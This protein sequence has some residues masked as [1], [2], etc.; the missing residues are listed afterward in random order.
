MDEIKAKGSLAALSDLKLSNL[1]V[2]GSYEKLEGIVIPSTTEEFIRDEVDKPIDL[3]S[4]RV[5]G[6]IRFLDMN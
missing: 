6:K 5:R 3:L 2:G 4:E 1:P